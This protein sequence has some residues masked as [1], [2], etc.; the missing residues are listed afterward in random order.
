M[1]TT[2]ISSFLQ[3]ARRAIGKFCVNLGQR[4]FPTPDNAFMSTVSGEKFF[5]AFPRKFFLRIEDVAHSLS[6]CCRYNGHVNRFYSVAEHS[7][8]LARYV[9]KHV[10]TNEP[11][12][13][14]LMLVYEAL[15]HD[16][17]EA[18]LTD[19]PSPLKPFIPG[20]KMLQAIVDRVVRYKLRLPLE[21][22]P[23][24]KEFDTRILIDERDQNRSRSKQMWMISDDVKSLGV[25]LQFFSPEEAKEKYLNM[26]NELVR[27]LK[28]EGLEMEFAQ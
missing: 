4:I 3:E 14:N 13:E 2:M 28:A 12:V 10:Y 16:D 21:E 15:H 18:Y 5:P 26:H 19:I 25:E 27:M 20:Y 1:A 22:T 11:T 8:L 17:G 7:W 24:L 23:M 6:M 9:L